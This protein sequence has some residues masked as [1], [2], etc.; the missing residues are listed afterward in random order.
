[1]RTGRQ[2]D[3]E[4]SEHRNLNSAAFW[5]DQYE[6][7]EASRIELLAQIA[8]VERERDLLHGQPSTE[9]SSKRK[10]DSGWDSVASKPTKRA[11]VNKDSAAQSALVTHDSFSEDFNTLETI[12]KCKAFQL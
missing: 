8:R 11:R 6:Q 9:G 5:R 1:L 4:E 2:R 10:R 7:A 3:A 12:G